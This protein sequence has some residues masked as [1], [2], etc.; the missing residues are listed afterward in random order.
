MSEKTVGAFEAKTHFSALID[1]AERGQTT[2]VTKR[3]KP[4]A[5][6][7]PVSKSTPSLTPEAA[8]KGLLS[9]DA[10]LGGA[11]LRSLVEKGRRF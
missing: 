4:I 5:Q 1:A 8:M 10:R 2:I 11:T 9:I 6:I 7:G 3:G